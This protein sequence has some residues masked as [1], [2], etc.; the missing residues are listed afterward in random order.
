MGSNS[1]LGHVVNACVGGLMP[2]QGRRRASSA[3]WSP[4]I[5]RTVLALV[6]LWPV[7]TR[8]AFAQS[9][10]AGSWA[11]RNTE[12]ISRDSY[13]VDYVGIPLNAEGRLRALS[14][15]ESQLAMIE[16][17]CGMWPPFYLV[18]GPFGMKIWNDTD[19]V[20]GNTAFWKIGDDLKLRDYEMT[21]ES[22]SLNYLNTVF[23]VLLVV[24]ALYFL[25][26]KKL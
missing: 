1:V 18:K 9:E 11:A 15:N 8:S 25:L 10:L 6:L 2:H 19:S 20:S 5:F 23:T 21:A 24:L 7:S 12:D 4:V 26:R 17:Q 16:R 13:P 22:R 14:Y 3:N